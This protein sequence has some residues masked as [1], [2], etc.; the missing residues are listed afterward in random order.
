MTTH[1]Y[2][3]PWHDGLQYGPEFYETAA[4]PTEYR[5]FLIFN[6]FKGSW[7]LVKDGVC[8][9]Q[10]AGKNGPRILA[11]A[12]CGDDSDDCP[13]NVERARVIAAKHGVDLPTVP[14]A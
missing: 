11:D 8:L 13:F 4:K 5:G 2:R 1:R 3:N 14:A 12:L 9:T 10:R 7:E 6:R